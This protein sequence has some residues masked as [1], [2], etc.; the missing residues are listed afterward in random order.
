MQIEKT[1]AFHHYASGGAVYKP[2]FLKGAQGVVVMGLVVAGLVLSMAGERRKEVAILVAATLTVALVLFVPPVCAGAIKVFGQE[3]IV[4][5]LGA[6]LN[7]GM[8]LLAVGGVSASAK[9][10]VRWWWL[11]SLLSVGA[12]LLGVQS[13]GEGDRFGWNWYYQRAKAPREARH[14]T[15]DELYAVR[16]FFRDHIPAGDT[17]LADPQSSMRLVMLHDCHSVALGRGGGVKDLAQ[18]LADVGTIV[19]PSTPWE[20]R[21]R[22]L[23][24]YGI[25]VCVVDTRFIPEEGLNWA[26]AHRRSE[27]ARLGTYVLVKISTE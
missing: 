17:V 18:R 26:Y 24:R 13:A 3:W 27:P 25:T 8:L 10:V 12:F 23:R 14:A 22:L 9:R 11:R 1:D 19:G 2:E 15:L 20:T 16:E 5:R 21:R 4:G 7:V 6:L